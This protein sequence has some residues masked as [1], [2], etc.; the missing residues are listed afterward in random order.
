MEKC[1]RAIPATDDNIIWRTHLAY[2]ITK[3]ISTH[4]QNM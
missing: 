2:W 4:T 1:G 3:A